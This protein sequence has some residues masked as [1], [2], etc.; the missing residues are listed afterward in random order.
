[1]AGLRKWRVNKRIKKYQ[2][3]ISIGVSKV[4]LESKSPLDDAIHDADKKMYQSKI[5]NKKN[6]K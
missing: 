1:M 4:D 5:K 3:S 2:I 6:R